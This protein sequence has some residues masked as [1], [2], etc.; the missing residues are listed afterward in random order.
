MEGSPIKR[1]LKNPGLSINKLISRARRDAREV[2]MAARND[3]TKEN[4]KSDQKCMFK[5]H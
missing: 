3:P 2:L 4:K 5:L 1:N